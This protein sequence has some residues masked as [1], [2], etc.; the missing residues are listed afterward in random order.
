MSELGS[1]YLAIIPKADKAAMSGTVSEIKS[2]LGEA[3]ES[4]GKASGKGFGSWFQSAAG[5]FVGNIA[6]ELAAAGADAVKQ[7]FSMAYDGYAEY[8]QLI[9]GMDT[10]YGESSAQMQ[11]YAASAYK[12]MQMSANDYMDLATSF[13]ASLVSSLG[14]D[15]AAAATYANMA[16]GDMADNANKMGTSMEDIENAYKGF[17]KQN[18]TMLDNLKL[19]YGGTQAEMKR[20]LADAQNIKAAN[21]EMVEYS[22]DSFADMVDAIHVVQENMGIT[23]VSTEE[24]ATTIQGS[25]AMMKSAWENWLVSLGTGDYESITTGFADAVESTNVM[26]SNALP[27]IQTIVMS[28]VNV[29]GEQLYQACPEQVQ[30]IID[31]V[32]PIVTQIVDMAAAVGEGLLEIVGPLLSTILENVTTTGETLIEV[33]APIIE[34]VLT[35]ATQLGEDLSPVIEAIVETVRV[36]FDTISLVINTALEIVGALW[37][38]FWPIFKETMSGVIDAL[39]PI[40]ENGMALVQSVLNTVTALIKGDWD[41]VWSGI[42]DILQNVWDLIGSIVSGGISL[43]KSV[44]LGGLDAISAF[45]STTWAA[46]KSLVSGALDGIKSAVSGGIDGVVGFFRNLPGNILGAL[47]SLGGLLWD[48]GSSI[49]S[50]LLNGI[51]SSIGSVYDFVGGIAD[52]IASLKGPIPYDLKLLVP[53]GKAIMSGLEG[54]LE[55]GFAPILDMVSD[56]ASDM[57]VSFG[58]PVLSVEA[59]AASP[60][61]VSATT[62]RPATG[63]ESAAFP[64]KLLERAVALLES[65][66][67]KDADVYLDGTKVSAGLAA[68]STS[69][70]RGRGLAWT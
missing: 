6:A 36:A 53:N 66:D 49:V 23:G 30:G 57:E 29:L 58:S 10:L 13:A 19:G 12:N 22:I 40:V 20:L 65:I 52:K 51:K 2:E 47:G 8:E 14:G 26:L 9:G 7:L 11:S 39:A 45:W 1:A 41:G 44:I 68:V 61:L 50:G 16:I 56:M 3:G 27:A 21:G 43:A 28:A 5:V 46:L 62:V 25:T 59:T 60:S 42:K 54:G 32:A 15:T 34:E 70:A 64:V 63:Q 24:A 67:D 55:E 35:Y 31:Q 33:L 37:N 18:Y 69:T 38:E 48:A 17:S 4:A